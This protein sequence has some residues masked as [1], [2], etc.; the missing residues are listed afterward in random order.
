ME[1]EPTLD[2]LTITNTNW[3]KLRYL[4]V[5][6]CPFAMFTSLLGSTKDT[7]INYTWNVYNNL[8]THLEEL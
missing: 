3:K 1:K 2:C 8:F 5:L 4:I 7:T 6:L